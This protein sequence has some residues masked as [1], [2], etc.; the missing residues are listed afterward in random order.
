MARQADLQR[1]VSCLY[2]SY[3]ATSSGFGSGFK[4]RARD[5]I[6]LVGAALAANNVG[7]AAE[8]APTRAAR[9]NG[10]FARFAKNLS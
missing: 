9:R 6:F 8:A 4:R 2:P 3:A 10:Q 7:F 5:P 1:W